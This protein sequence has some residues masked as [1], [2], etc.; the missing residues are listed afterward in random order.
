MTPPAPR[1]LF[2]RGFR[3]EKDALASLRCTVWT[4][5]EPGPQPDP[6]LLDRIRARPD[7]RIG[8]LV[9]ADWLTE[10]GDP[11]AEL[12]HLDDPPSTYAIRRLARDLVRRYR[13]LDVPDDAGLVATWF[14]GHLRTA[15]LT[16]TRENAW[17]P[18][19]LLE[20]PRTTRC[21]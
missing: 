9:L 8:Y 1:S 10:P 18:I 14:M 5:G 12:V 2:L 11:H 20:S 4:D 13:L 3:V 6:T 17:A 16:R 21:R 15:R 7:D 19:H